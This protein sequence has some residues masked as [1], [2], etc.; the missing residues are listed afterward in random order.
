MPNSATAQEESNP[1]TKHAPLT[2]SGRGAASA[3]P[4][5]S[6]SVTNAA[7]RIKKARP[8]AAGSSAEAPEAA[9]TLSG[10]FHSLQDAPSDKGCPKKS[11]LVWT[12]EL[13]TRFLFAV[14]QIGLRTAV[15]RTILQVCAS[16]FTNRT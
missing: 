4:G 16:L 11:R 5:A 9:L 15:P 2:L 1:D 10:P 13:H 14:E 6:S 7:H 3:T 12:P 8:M